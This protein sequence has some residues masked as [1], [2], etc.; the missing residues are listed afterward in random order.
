[1][2]VYFVLFSKICDQNYIL[3]CF[4]VRISSCSEALKRDCQELIF[5]PFLRYIKSF[6]KSLI[7]IHIYLEQEDN[8]LNWISFL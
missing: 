7:S 4:F 8:H 2:F 5:Y 6:P 1:M 3:L